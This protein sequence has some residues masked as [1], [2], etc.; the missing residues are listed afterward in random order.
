MNGRQSLAEA[1]ARQERC[2]DGGYCHGTTFAAGSEPCEPTACYRVTAAGPLSG[3]FPDD[4]WPQDVLVQ[5]YQ[6]RY[7]VP[8]PSTAPIPTVDEPD[9]E[10]ERAAERARQKARRDALSRAVAA[11]RSTPTRAHRPPR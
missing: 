5:A 8:H 4:R 6:E 10:T 7:G 11:H 1:I 2:P 3:V 9:P